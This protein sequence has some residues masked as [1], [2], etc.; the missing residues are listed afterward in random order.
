MARNGPFTDILRMR[1]SCVFL[2]HHERISIQLNALVQLSQTRIQRV[3]CSEMVVEGAVVLPESL[4]KI[5][6]LETL[7]FQRFNKNL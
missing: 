1:T 2:V 7:P 4:H 5:I 6:K 3:P